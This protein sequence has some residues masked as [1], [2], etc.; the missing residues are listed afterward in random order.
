MSA[1]APTSTRP[2]ANMVDGE[3]AFTDADFRKISAMVHGDAGIHLPDAKATLVYSRL[4]KRLRAL[5]LTSF[6]DYCALVAG[7]DGVDE[8]QKMLAALTT[9]VTRFFREPHHFDH[10]K[11]RVLP[12]LL[13]A[14]RSGGKVRIWSAAC[15]SG[16]E[17]FSI[18]MT[19]LSLMPEAAGRDVKIL[20]TDIDPN[21]V[22]EGRGGAYAP[23][24]LEGIPDGYRKR[25]TSPTAD[26]RVKMSDDL[27]ELI[28]FNELNLIGDWPMKG[29][30]DAIFC[31]NV[32]IYFEDDTQARLWSR[33]A[34]L[35]KVGG[36]L[37]IGHSERIQG[38]AVAAYKP[39]GVTTYR[40]IQESAR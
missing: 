5:G 37:Y 29:Q 26:G 24:L 1:S 17:P 28:T 25:W 8:R 20:A 34:P 15:S 2:G 35:N 18:A 11:E 4:A 38:P 14:A 9:N 40:R 39:D 16:Q 27:R 19:I 12:P 23:H 13:D 31:R 33:F 10:L 6:K 21:M 30:F 36:A 22:A 32:A 3:F 7:A